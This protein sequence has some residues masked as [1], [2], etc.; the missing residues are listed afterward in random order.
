[1]M[2]DMKQLSK[3]IVTSYYQCFEIAIKSSIYNFF[4]RHFMHEHQ[5]G[6]QHVC[7]P[8]A[9]QKFAFGPSQ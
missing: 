4:V 5:H 8:P 1:M 7:A 2:V 6:A 9:G 3:A